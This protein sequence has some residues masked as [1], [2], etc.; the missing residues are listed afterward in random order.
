MARAKIRAILK[1][2]S[3][4]MKTKT[5]VARTHANKQHSGHKKPRLSSGRKKKSSSRAPHI[6]YTRTVLPAV[7]TVLRHTRSQSQLERVW[8]H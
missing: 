2:K 1:N 7:T 3:G 6:T 5:K 8:Q 4:L